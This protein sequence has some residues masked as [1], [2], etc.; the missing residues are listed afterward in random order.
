[1]VQEQHTNII[2][3]INRSVLGRLD[4]LH[5]SAGVKSVESKR[6]RFPH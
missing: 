2:L 5:S 6:V 1:M 4:R 3:I